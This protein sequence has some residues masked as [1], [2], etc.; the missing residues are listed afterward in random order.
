MATGE[1]PWSD[2]SY[3]QMIQLVAVLHHRPPIP[4]TLPKDLV[5]VLE[6]CWHRQPEKRPPF[7][8]LLLLF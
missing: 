8:D 7:E 4:P 2:K 3:H 6:S 5:P 1:L